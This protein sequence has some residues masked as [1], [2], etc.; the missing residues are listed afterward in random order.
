VLLLVLV[1]LLPCGG[2]LARALLGFAYVL[3]F[4]WIAA[5]CARAQQ[6]AA[7]HALFDH[8]ITS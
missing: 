7:V 3:G 2:G 4:A 1:L 6:R 5:L 8:G